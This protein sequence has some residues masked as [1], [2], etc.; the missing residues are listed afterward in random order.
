ML[1]TSSYVVHMFK[2]TILSY[3]HCG[4]KK[5]SEQASPVNEYEEYYSDDEPKMDKFGNY[6]VGDKAKQDD[7]KPTM[8]MQ[9]CL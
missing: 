1:P 7:E 4:E 2:K 9:L 6:I 5:K 8:T 3:N